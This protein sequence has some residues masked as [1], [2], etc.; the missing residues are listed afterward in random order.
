MTSNPYQSPTATAALT[1]RAWFFSSLASLLPAAFP[2]LLTAAFYG[3]WLSGWIA[4]GHAPR[5]YLDDPW[6]IGFITRS[7]YIFACIVLVS[8]PA[9]VLG[10]LSVY[11]WRLFRW[12]WSQ[13]V[14]YTCIIATIWVAAFTLLRADPLRVVDWF[15]D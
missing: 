12:D 4:L 11:I 6:E 9:G 13:R 1:P 14:F 8:M 3:A 7:V 10:S 2:V 15:F 5:P